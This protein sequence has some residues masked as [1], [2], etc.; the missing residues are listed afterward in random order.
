MRSIA[1][2][3]QWTPS[4]KASRCNSASSRV[5]EGMGSASHEKTHRVNFGASLLLQSHGGTSNKHL[6]ETSESLSNL[7]SNYK[8]TNCFFL[9]PFHRGQGS[10]GAVY[11]NFPHAGSVGG[12]FDGHPLVNWRHDTWLQEVTWTSWTR[13]FVS[14]SPPGT[15]LIFL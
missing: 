11:Y 8:L 6:L 15:Q 1:L 7:V 2:E 4:L 12:F 3:L 9:H 14:V 5:Q 10:L 13:F